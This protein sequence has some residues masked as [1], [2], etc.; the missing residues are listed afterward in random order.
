[1][2]TTTEEY[3]LNQIRILLLLVTVTLIYEVILLL[4]IQVNF[5]QEKSIKVMKTQL[6]ILNDIK[7][8]FFSVLLRTGRSE[9]FNVTYKKHL[10]VRQCQYK[11]SVYKF[12][13][14]RSTS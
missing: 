6:W 5:V 12:R 7:N 3:L 1:M 10:A 8:L 13:D 11:P 14:F 2:V 4:Q 9:T